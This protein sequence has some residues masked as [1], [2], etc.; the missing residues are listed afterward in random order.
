MVVLDVL[1]SI[2]VPV[3]RI[4]TETPVP[5]LGISFGDLLLAQILIGIAIAILRSALGVGGDGTSYRSGSSKS[6]RISDERKGDEF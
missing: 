5:G 1:S 6:A 2:F 3:W 4:F